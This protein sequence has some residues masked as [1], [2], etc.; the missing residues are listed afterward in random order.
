VIEKSLVFL[1]VRELHTDIIPV[2]IETNPCMK[3]KGS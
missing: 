2:I 3:E 1:C